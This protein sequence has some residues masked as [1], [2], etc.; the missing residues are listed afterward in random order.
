M[1]ILETAR[2]VKGYSRHKRPPA[3]RNKDKISKLCKCLKDCLSNSAYLEKIELYNIPLSAKDSKQLAKVFLIINKSFN[4]IYY[5]F[6]I[7]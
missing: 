6:L 2:L 4:C 7:N 3:I 1:F 5:S